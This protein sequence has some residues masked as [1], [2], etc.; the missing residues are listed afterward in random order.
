MTTGGQE[1]SDC[2]ERV[3]QRDEAAARALVDRVQPLVEKLVRAHLPRNDDVEDLMQDVFLKL[4]SRLGQYRGQVPFEHWV[5]RVAVSTCIDRLRAQ[6]RRPAVRWSD[7]TEGEQA[8]VESLAA[9][10]SGGSKEQ[11]AWGIMEKLLAALSPTERLIIS[12]ADMEQKSIREICELTG[13]NSGVVRIRAF[14]ARQKL[15]SLYREL[16]EGRL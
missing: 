9:E 13:W 14:R 7:L 11:D 15:K 4:F 1:L 3:R 5:S 12:L 10:P 16:E 8:V 2:L 6:K